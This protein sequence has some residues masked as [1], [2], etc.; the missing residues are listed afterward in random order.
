VG[1]TW[2]QRGLCG[3]GATCMGGRN[4]GRK[5]TEGA[6]A[7]GLPLKASGTD[8]PVLYWKL[9]SVRSHINTNTFSTIASAPGMPPPRAACARVAMCCS[10]PVCNM[11]HLEPRNSEQFAHM[12]KP[13]CTPLDDDPCA[14]AGLCKARPCNLYRHPNVK[15]E[16]WNRWE[17]RESFT[18]LDWVACTAP[19]EAVLSRRTNDRTGIHLRAHP[20]TA[21]PRTHAVPTVD[22]T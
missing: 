22:L 17:A 20:H 9:H 7:W 12:S 18:H 13:R 16:H 19:T 4:S 1:A 15:L 8:R 2:Y 11:F 3:I 21:H 14:S 10:R 6:Y 5:V